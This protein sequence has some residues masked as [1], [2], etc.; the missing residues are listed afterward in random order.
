MTAWRKCG[1]PLVRRSPQPWR[2]RTGQA[3][4]KE[5]VEDE[6][7]FI[8]LAHSPLWFNYE[9]PQVNPIPEEM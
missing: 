6:A 2:T 9:Y 8:D 5:L 7:R 3:A 4:A 1:G